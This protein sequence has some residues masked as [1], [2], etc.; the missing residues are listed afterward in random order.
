M[1]LPEPKNPLS[2]KNHSPV[3]QTIRPALKEIA[4]SIMRQLLKG[5][6]QMK[7]IVAGIVALTAILWGAQV[8]AGDI[9]QDVNDLRQ[10]RQDTWKDRQDLRQD[11]QDTWKDGQDIRHDR[12]DIRGDRQ[13][14]RQDL[15]SGNWSAAAADRRDLHND[16][17]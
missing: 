12:Q 16:R 2:K 11:R 3:N 15:R 7:R 17:R 13:Q 9:Q 8:Y 4:A 6:H 14:L 10:D 5:R 1:Y